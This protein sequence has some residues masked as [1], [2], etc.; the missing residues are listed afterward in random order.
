MLT[1]RESWTPTGPAGAVLIM[2]LT[3]YQHDSSSEESATLRRAMSA[4]I[5]PQLYD[6]SAFGLLKGNRVWRELF[7][8]VTGHI[9]A[10]AST[11][12]DTYDATTT[13]NQLH[14]LALDWPHVRAKLL[15]A[16]RKRVSR[17]A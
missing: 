6:G 17:T 12:A 11:Y 3:A 16:E 10:G 15:E 9:A 8:I 13:A 4:M 7:D 5:D 1:D 14:Q 2:A